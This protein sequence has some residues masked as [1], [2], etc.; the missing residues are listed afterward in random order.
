MSQT[1]IIDHGRRRPD[2]VWE[3]EKSPQT[4]FLLEGFNHYL[5]NT[6]MPATADKYGK[7]LGITRQDSDEFACLSHTRA[8]QAQLAYWL[9]T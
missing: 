9:T 6:N 2:S 8:K 3:F 1:N 7:Q 5:F 4:D